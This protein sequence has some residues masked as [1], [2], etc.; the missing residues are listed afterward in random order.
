MLGKTG[1][2]N[3]GYIET[4]VDDTQSDSTVEYHNLNNHYDNLYGQNNTP[5]GIFSSCHKCN[6]LLGVEQLPVTFLAVTKPA[7]GQATYSLAAF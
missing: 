4:C 6:K 2:V 3:N 5:L 1:V 7:T